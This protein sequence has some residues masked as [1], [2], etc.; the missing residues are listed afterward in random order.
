MSAPTL[1]FPPCL[2]PSIA[3]WKATQRLLILCHLSNYLRTGYSRWERPDYQTEEFTQTWFSVIPY[4]LTGNHRNSVLFDP[5]VY[6][7]FCC[8]ICISQTLKTFSHSVGSL[9]LWMIE[10]FAMQKLFSFMRSQSLIVDF[11]ARVIQVIQKSCFLSSIRFRVLGP[12]LRSLTHLKLG[13][14]LG[15]GRCYFIFDL[16]LFSS[17][18]IC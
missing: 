18:T 3:W 4:L 10:S 8:Y 16:P 14:V 7:Y 6:M 11:N 1:L 9:F 2:P 13:F 15:E 5:I 17:T 12:M